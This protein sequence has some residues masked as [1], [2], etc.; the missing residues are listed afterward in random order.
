LHAIRDDVHRRFG[1]RPPRTVRRLVGGRLNRLLG[2]ILTLEAV[3]VLGLGILVWHANAANTIDDR[4]ATAVY[5]PPGTAARAVAGVITQFGSPA[6][7]ILGALIVA[8]WA[9]IHLRDRLLILFCPASVFLAAV[10]ESGLKK[11]VARARPATALLA[12]ERSY[13][14]PSGHA[15]AAAALA[16]AT[17]ILIVAAGFAWRRVAVVALASYS[18]AISATRLVLGVH[19]LTD[20]VAANALAGAVVLVVAWATTRAEPSAPTATTD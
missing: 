5:A 19:Y 1:G 8:A 10:S 11:V 3:L 14:F 2:P 7:A 16:L 20:V 6:A 17:A 12:H 13:S 15:T 18:L 4:V 9:W